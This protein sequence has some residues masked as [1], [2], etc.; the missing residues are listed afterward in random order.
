[1]EAWAETPEKWH[2][3]TAPANSPSATPALVTYEPSTLPVV[4]AA[5]PKANISSTA[6]IQQ[7]PKASVAAAPKP[8]PKPKPAVVRYTIKKGDTLGR[9]AS[10]Q[11]VSLSALRR[12]NGLSGDMIHP[13]RT[14]TIP[15]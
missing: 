8:K 6:Q 14:L 10:N 2:R 13:G 3:P 11:G 15:K 9:I 1:M 12:A 4:T 5:K 7:K